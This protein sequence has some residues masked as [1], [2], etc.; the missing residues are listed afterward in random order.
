MGLTFQQKFYNI[1]EEVFIIHE[2]N[3]TGYYGEILAMIEIPEDE[4]EA[5][6]LADKLKDFGYVNRMN[7]D[8]VILKG[9]ELI[10]KAND[11][12]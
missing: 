1:G 2:Y 4:E 8:D 11:D 5:K 9:Y 7:F 12:K 6:I 3:G 10:K